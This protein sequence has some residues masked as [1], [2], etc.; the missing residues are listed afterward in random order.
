MYNWIGME[1]N[2]YLQCLDMLIVFYY[3]KYQIK[4][5][6]PTI[7]ITIRI[8]IEYIS[9]NRPSKQGLL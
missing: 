2:A 7:I 8:S 5:H 6:L 9:K 1:I 4:T 3:F